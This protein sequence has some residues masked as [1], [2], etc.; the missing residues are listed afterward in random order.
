[1]P[2]II[3][4]SRML[5]LPDTA[6]VE[7]LVDAVRDLQRKANMH[8]KRAD[9]INTALSDSQKRLKRAEDPNNWRATFTGDETTSNIERTSLNHGNLIT[10][11]GTGQVMMHFRPCCQNLDCRCT[12]RLGPGGTCVCADDD[13][14]AYSLVDARA[15]T[16]KRCARESCSNRVPTSKRAASREDGFCSDTCA[17]RYEAWG[18]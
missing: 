16:A 15:E 8:Q 3:P 4:L 11:E 12:S 14:I 5:G 2:N 18:A 17:A 1:M 13:P 9:D 10:I 6:G 7:Q